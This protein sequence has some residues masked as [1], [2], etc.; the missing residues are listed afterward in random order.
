MRTRGIVGDTNELVLGV[1]V[2]GTF[3]DIV[4]MGDGAPVRTKVPSTPHDP[5][6]GVLDAVDQVAVR[7]GTDR[8]GLLPRLGRFGLGT[9]V[10]TN[11]LATRTG[12]RLGLVTTKG[13]E[14]LVPLARG[15]RVSENGWLVP[16]PSLVDRTCIVGIDERVN[17]DGI[18]LTDVDPAN[19]IESVA[20][21]VD[22]EHIDTIVVSFLWSFRNPINEDAA[23]AAIASRWP[24]LRVVCGAELA[25]VIREYDRTQFAL[26]NAY[27][28][29]SLDWLR[30]LAEQLHADGLVPP[31][32]LTHSGGGVTTVEAARRTPIGLAQSGPAAGGAAA[33][34]LSAARG[35]RDVVTC[36]LGGTSLDVALVSEG[37][38]LRRT[39]GMVVGQWTSLSMVDVD[40]VGSGGGSIAWVDSVGA[41]R[42]GPQSAGAVPGPACYGRGGADPTVTDALVVLGYLEP[43]AFLGGRMP[44]DAAAALD[45]C[46]RLGGPLGLDASETAWGIR[47]V[48]LAT[49][50]RAVRGRIASRGLVASELTLLAY[51]G[52][53]G[54]FAADIAADVG[55]RRTVIPDLAPVFSAYGAAT[56]PLRR[57]RARSV[58][59]RIPARAQGLAEVFAG[60][61]AEVVT[62][63]LAD[64]LVSAASMV[65]FEADVRFERQ[66]A[67]ITVAVPRDVNGSADVSG[68]AEEFRA[69]YARRFGAGAMSTGVI[70]EA[71]TLRAVGTELRPEGPPPCGASPGTADAPSARMVRMSRDL[72]STNVPVYSGA[73]LRPRESLTGPAIIDAGDTTIWVAVGYSAQLDDAGSLVITKE[74]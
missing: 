31:V 6:M 4:V 2:G 15:S 20:G 36:D 64:G 17:R 52:C 68:L 43:A 69:E 60:L 5:A 63:L 23:R 34:S 57:E 1:D 42:V 16:P 50:A 37:A 26:L 40:S 3:T 28:D 11:V 30:T 56:A 59:V 33:L 24:N 49:M 46:A 18:V 9:T 12:R 51:G 7:F 25:P 22:R 47:E 48:A 19:V 58:A 72:P 32:V 14:D 45:A 10:V 71:M 35:E 70:V 55:S 29:G 53:G 54:L 67:E 21:L 61:E 41:I 27:V 73:S 44:L 62:D 38:L 39:R 65:M 66:G 8:R 74:A 13:F